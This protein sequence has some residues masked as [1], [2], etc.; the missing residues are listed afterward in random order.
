MAGVEKEDSFSWGEFINSLDSKDQNS[1]ITEKDFNRVRLDLSKS[2]LFPKFRVSQSHILIYILGILLSDLI[3]GEPE[4]QKLKD[5]LENLRFSHLRTVYHAE[6]DSDSVSDREF[7]K[8][9]WASI[10]NIFPG[11]SVNSTV[12][13]AFNE[14]IEECIQHF[15]GIKYISGILRTSKDY[16][17]LSFYVRTN[18]GKSLNINRREQ[19]SFRFDLISNL[20]YVFNG[21]GIGNGN[22]DFFSR[23]DHAWFSVRN[24]ST[25]TQNICMIF[26]KIEGIFIWKFCLL[27]LDQKE[28]ENL[29]VNIKN[30]NGSSLMIQHKRDR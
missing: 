27:K 9:G 8:A 30:F 5:C 24:V 28:M 11:F 4:D 21:I 16:A 7:F 20:N 1:A 3:Q 13:R 22:G 18:T 10:S 14:G 12:K 17:N 2:F 25:L 23:K 19:A 6:S 15:S 26:W 29:F